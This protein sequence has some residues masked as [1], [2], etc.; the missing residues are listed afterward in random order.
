MANEVIVYLDDYKYSGDGNFDT[1]YLD[2]RTR[3]DYDVFIQQT[4][5]ERTKGSYIQIDNYRSPRRLRRGCY[6]ALNINMLRKVQAEYNFESHLIGRTYNFSR[7]DGDN[8]KHTHLLMSHQPLDASQL[9]SHHHNRLVLMERLNSTNDLEFRVNDVS[10]GN[11]NEIRQN[12][13]VR[14]VYDIGAPITASNA[15]LQHYISQYSSQYAVDHPNLILSHWDMDHYHCLMQMTDAEL[16]NFSKFICVDKMKSLTSKSLYN[17]MEQVLGSH[18]IICY[19]PRRR[20][21]QTAFPQMHELFQNESVSVY[22]GENSG[23][24]NYSGII[25]FVRGDKNHVFFTG[26]SLPCQAN[27]VLHHQASLLRLTPGHYLV[28]PHHGGDFKKAYKIYNLVAGIQAIEA[29]ISVDQGNNTYGHPKV[30]MLNWLA[31]IA[32]WSVE[33]TDQSGTMVRSL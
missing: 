5:E 23:T 24:T 11:W 31:S 15:E 9:S 13:K 27:Q 22:V 20:T 1:M 8:D 26:D 6:Y 28:V 33:R 12:G 14:L 29:I 10:Q 17:R 21:P 18:N 19:A 32:N 25:L 7:Y 2:F 30:S 4:G 3:G 16:R